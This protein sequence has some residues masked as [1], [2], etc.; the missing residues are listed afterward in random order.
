MIKNR[1]IQWQK[2]HF[3]TVFFLLVSF[4]ALG[5]ATNCLAKGGIS[6]SQT[7]VIFDAN[8]KSTKVTLNNRSDQV[9]LV[10]S[11]VQR[12]PDNTVKSTETLPFI[13]TPPLFRLEKESRNTVL[14]SKNDTSALP[15]DRESVFY[16]SFL[17]IPSVKKGIEANSSATT[18]QVSF[19]IRTLIKLFYR[20]EGLAISPLAAP[21]KFS[22]SSDGIMLHVKNPTPYYQT[23]AQLSVNGRLV[24]VR[25]QG[26]MV[27]PFSSQA[28]AVKGLADDIQ[29]S[30]IDDHGGL[31][32]TFRWTR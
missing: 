31:S 10:N 29:W 5:I 7:R 22:F 17:A 4:S 26:A 2:N 15:T 24:N 14:I 30:V 25:E 27:A 6:I 8:M 12:T 18:T 11:R 3:L 20:P 21:G 1:F 23:L 19:G 9:Y 16:L 32:E 13:V 28:Y